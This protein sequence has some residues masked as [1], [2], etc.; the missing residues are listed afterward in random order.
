W[1]ANA[2]GA[3]FGLTRKSGPAEIARAAL[4]SVGYQTRDLLDA[5]RADWPAGGGTGP[6]AHGGL[7]ASDPPLQVLAGINHPRG[8]RPAVM[9]TAALGAAYL[10]GRAA[11]VCPDLDGFA[12]SWK[13]ERRFEPQ[14]A[15]DLRDRKWAGWQDA[16]RRTLSAR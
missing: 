4:E 11:G 7:T 10:A 1:D 13:R 5:M 6:R 12:A 9:E 15:A 8:D 3:L 16:V 2:R 14:M